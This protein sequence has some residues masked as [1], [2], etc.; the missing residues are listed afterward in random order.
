[1]ATQP[2]CFGGKPSSALSPKHSRLVRLRVRKGGLLMG[3][4]APIQMGGF[5]KQ[6][7]R[8]GSWALDRPGHSGSFWNLTARQDN[9]G[10]LLLEKHRFSSALRVWPSRGVKLVLLL[11]SIHWTSRSLSCF[12]LGSRVSGGLAD[13]ALEGRGP[14][15]LPFLPSFLFLCSQ[16]PLFSL[17]I[18]E[19][20]HGSLLK[21]QSPHL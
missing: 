17:T 21:P 5:P 20:E 10:K 16:S 11:V 19:G 3:P 6:T 1:M 2:L 7:D 13:L 9:Q 18:T 12:I 14:P 15:S 4:P 8:E